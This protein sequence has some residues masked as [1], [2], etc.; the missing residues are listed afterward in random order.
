MPDHHKLVEEII[1]EA[2]AKGEFENLPGR[3]K[4]I[5]LTAYFN[6][7]AEYRV[8]HSVLKANKFVPEEVDLLREIGFLK[9]KLEACADAEK[10][11]KIN[12]E[13]NERQ[14][15]LAMLIERNKRRR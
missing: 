13:L 8:G 6:T 2:I 7:P 1:Q 15:A 5:D 14:M 11:Q 9:E 3:G 4:K 12:A 10:R